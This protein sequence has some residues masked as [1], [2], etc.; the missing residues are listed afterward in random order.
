M[1]SLKQ[2][3]EAINWE[4][5]RLSLKQ[6]DW[7]LERLL[8]EI[9]VD[10]PLGDPLTLNPNIYS[11]YTGVSVDELL[12][13]HSLVKEAF[14]TLA[15]H[16]RILKRGDPHYP[17]GGE[18]PRFLYARG[19]LDLLKMKRVTIAGTG[20]VS[21]QGRDYATESVKA[22]IEHNVAIVAGL[23]VGIEGIAHL[24]TLAENGMAIGVLATPLT[25]TFPESHKQLQ[26][27][28]GE[29]GL[30]LTQFSPLTQSERWHTI[31]RNKVMA[32]LSDATLVV[33]ERDGGGAV[34]QAFYAL[35]QEK[36]VALF[37]H[38]VEN[39]SLVWPRRLV[40]RQG[41]FSVKTPVAL[42]PILFP[43]AGRKSPAKPLPQQ[44][45]L[46]ESS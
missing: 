32:A 4:S 45:S 2:L 21:N 27:L 16:D 12:R 44:F 38:V 39:R 15:P 33:E 24:T 10:V 30:L 3:Q 5:L 19:N 35:E 37:K 17:E 11:R 29:R 8:D 31:L 9:G 28:I 46:F 41:V 42:Y 20:S 23:N 40:Q 36:R 6:E 26:T 22:L 18:L 1:E 13:A 43:T 34:K 7:Q 14:F 25:E